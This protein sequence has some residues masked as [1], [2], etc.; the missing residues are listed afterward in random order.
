MSPCAERFHAQRMLALYREGA[1]SQ[2][3]STR[4][5]VAARD[6]DRARSG[7]SRGP[8]FRIYRPRSSTKTR[9]STPPPPVAHGL[10]AQLEGGSPLLAGRER[11][12]AWLRERWERAIDGAVALLCSSRGQLGIGKTRLVAELATEVQ[13]R[14]WRSP[15]RRGQRRSRGSA[16]RQSAGPL[17]RRASGLARPR[18]RRRRARPQCSGPQPGSA[19]EVTG[20]SAP[21]LCRPSRRAG[22]TRLRRPARRPGTAERLPTPTASR[23]RRGGGDRRA[24]RAGRGRPDP[25]TDADRGQRRCSAS[26]APGGRRVGPGSEVAGRL[27]P[28]LPAGLLGERTGLRAAE[29]DLAENVV[30]LQA[31]GERH[32]P[33]LRGRGA[34]GHRQACASARSAAWSLPTPPTP[35]TSLVASASSPS[36]WLV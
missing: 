30:D 14:G 22:P 2:T 3:R 9:G 33:H 4:Y 36:W 35:S 26:G 17:E 21:D 20:H 13:S 29:A 24:L 5:R 8:G 28:T 12:L 23:I 6:T 16:G 27:A 11:E 31:A 18:L 10:P 32:S 25:P 1:D 34:R 19:S 7:S 15:L